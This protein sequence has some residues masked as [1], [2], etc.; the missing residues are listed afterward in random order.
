MLASAAQEIAEQLKKRAPLA[1]RLAKMAVHAAANAP[2]SV[3]MELEIAAQTVLQSTADMKEGMT[4][5]LEKRAP[6]FRGE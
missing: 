5:F 2:A 4:A 1:L 3:G 6:E